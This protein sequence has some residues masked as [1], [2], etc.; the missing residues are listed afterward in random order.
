M[1]L[2]TGIAMRDDNCFGF[3][4]SHRVVQA[5]ALLRDRFGETG[6]ISYFVEQGLCF[7]ELEEGHPPPQ[8]DWLRAH[9]MLRD[10]HLGLAL[11]PGEIAAEPSAAWK[12]CLHDGVLFS[13]WLWAPGDM[14]PSHPTLRL[15]EGLSCP[16]GSSPL[17][18][19]T[20]SL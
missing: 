7:R 19:V 8:A 4:R 14:M 18:C 6:D 9:Q 1:V 15:P 5:A 16:S 12:S 13:K 2:L 17:L 3:V 10:P 20:A 11:G